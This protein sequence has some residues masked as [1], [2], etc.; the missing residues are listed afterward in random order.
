MGQKAIL[1]SLRLG[2]ISPWKSEWFGSFEYS[3]LI[4]MDFKIRE[5]LNNI[6]FSLR[7]PCSDFNIQHYLSY[8]IFIDVDIYFSIDIKERLYLFKSK[9]LHI[10]DALDF[11]LQYFKKELSKVSLFYKSNM[12]YLIFYKY[13]YNCLFN[14]I[15][16]KFY[17]SYFIF[18]CFNIYTLFYF[19]VKYF[20]FFIR[21]KYISIFFFTF[22]LFIS[23]Y[24]IFNSFR[25]T[26]GSLV[27]ITNNRE[28]ESNSSIIFKIFSK[29]INKLGILFNIIKAISF[30]TIHSLVLLKHSRLIVFLYRLNVLYLL[31]YSKLY[32][33]FSLLY[34]INSYLFYYLFLFFI[35]SKHFYSFDL[36]V[37]GYFNKKRRRF[38]LKY[39]YYK[40]PHSLKFLG[41]SLFNKLKIFNIFKFPLLNTN[42]IHNYQ[43]KFKILNIVFTSFLYF[44]SKSEFLYLFFKYSYSFLYFF[45]YIISFFFRFFFFFFY[46]M[47]FCFNS[48]IQY[49]LVIFFCFF[50]NIYTYFIVFNMYLLFSIINPYS[51]LSTYFSNIFSNIIPILKHTDNNVHSPF[52][53]FFFNRII[54]RQFAFIIENALFKYSYCSFLFAANYY[55]SDY[56]PLNN[57]RLIAQ[58]ISYEI[59]KGSPVPELFRDLKTFYFSELSRRGYLFKR[60]YRLKRF[61][62]VTDII[63]NKIRK[64]IYFISK[65]KNKRSFY[66]YFNSI[67]TYRRYILNFRLFSLF[68]KCNNFNKFLSL[69]FKP[70]QVYSI[71]TFL[72]SVFKRSLISK[73]LLLSIY[74]NKSNILVYILI[75]FIRNTF[76]S[77]YPKKLIY[78][79]LI[80]FIS[81]FSKSFKLRKRYLILQNLK[82]F[83]LFHSYNTMYSHLYNELSILRNKFVLRFL[84]YYSIEGMRL[85]ISGTFKRGNEAS[86]KL[87]THG[88]IP[89]SSISLDVSQFISPAYTRNGVLG[90]KVY[91]YFNT[92]FFIDDIELK[93]EE[94]LERYNLLDKSDLKSQHDLNFKSKKKRRKSK[95]NAK[96]LYSIKSK[97]DSGYFKP[98]YSSKSK[99]SKYFYSK[100][101]N[102]TFKIKNNK[103][104]TFQNFSNSRNKSKSS[105]KYSSKHKRKY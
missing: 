102:S 81:I 97:K 90:V 93:S 30:T 99:S 65:F 51:L 70:N 40:L 7:L 82:N 74:Q 33:I 2:V 87:Y 96:T 49:L 105:F 88:R 39:T 29:Y 20:T 10:F 26:H 38:L 36:D 94:F 84:K 1:N 72:N 42:F 25:S 69:F 11:I 75:N 64:H 53:P 60:I 85:L 18:N 91:F 9:D 55:M 86:S 78:L 13:L 48:Y 92:D 67:I 50:L 77:F 19:F 22:N 6:F 15:Y 4:S 62:P 28:S 57:T 104:N 23:N 63:L 24:F 103:N 58:Y 17:Y 12:K 3:S 100:G 83:K 43:N 59:E 52:E 73:T 56:L 89:K 101:N 46:F 95:S 80:Y 66:S 61:H 34:K 35:K 16:R 5:Y 32:Y 37:D 98:S 68:L 31:Q 54:L 8:L 71:D 41:T 76:K 47:H 21:L 79:Y 27:S 14:S 45:K 44:I